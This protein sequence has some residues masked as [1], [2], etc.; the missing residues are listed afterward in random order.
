MK[1]LSAKQSMEIVIIGAGGN[2]SHFFRNLLQDLAI[3]K[4]STV[5]TS[6]VS[7]TIVDG[8]LVEKKNLSNQLFDE[9][10]IGVS[11]VDALCERYGTHYNIDCYAIDRYITSI[12]ELS[13]LFLHPDKLSVLVSCVDNNRTRMLMHEYF[14][15]KDVANLM[16]IDVGIEGVILKE[17][18]KDD[19][20]GDKKIQTSGFSGQVVTGYKQSG[21]VF[22]PPVADVYGTILTDQ[23]SVFPTQSCGDDMVNNPQRCETNKLAAQMTNVV[24]NNLFFTGELLQ[25]EITFNAR[26]GTSQVR[27]IPKRIEDEFINFFKERLNNDTSSIVS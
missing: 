10:D 17:E 20:R 9:D 26:F 22:L 25:E 16:Y 21:Q 8:D 14:H 15:H 5:R 13:A 12:E 23:E 18:L 11:K 1:I 27:F 3:Y 24:L 7:I 2:G 4:N 6:K 19:P